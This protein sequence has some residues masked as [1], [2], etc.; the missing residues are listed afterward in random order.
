MR[1]LKTKVPG[2]YHPFTRNCQSRW[3]LLLLLLF[4][5]LLPYLF[6][7]YIFSYLWLL[8]C[9]DY[10]SDCDYYFYI[11][12]YIYIYVCIYVYDI[13]I[14]TTDTLYNPNMGTYMDMVTWCLIWVKVGYPRNGT[15]WKADFTIPF[16]IGSGGG[17]AES[18]A[19]SQ[20]KMV[21]PDWFRDAAGSFPLVIH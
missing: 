12:I 9:Y 5:V 17:W 10:V 11:N 6:Y 19:M 20:K 21:P 4:F 2:S 3:L 1:C 13:C 8:S 18:R 7:I 15:R 14:S 16:R